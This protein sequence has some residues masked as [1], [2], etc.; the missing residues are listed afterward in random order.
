ML[1]AI[2]IKR[3]MRAIGLILRTE[4]L[5]IEAVSK[6]A[7]AGVPR[8]AG[9]HSAIEG[10]ISGL[11]SCRGPLAAALGVEALASGQT[12]RLLLRAIVIG[13]RKGAALRRITRNTKGPS[14]SGKDRQTQ[15]QWRNQ[16]CP[17]HVS[18]SN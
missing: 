10:E 5:S 16:N 1:M 9:R 11:L 14:R 12:V 2:S 4:T 8:I 17:T 15:R 7:L 6:K 3:A 18:A 13:K